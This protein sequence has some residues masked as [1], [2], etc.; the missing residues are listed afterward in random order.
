MDSRHTRPVGPYSCGNRKGS[1]VLQNIDPNARLPSMSEITIRIAPGKTLDAKVEV[2]NGRIIVHSRSGAGANARN[3]DYRPAL[4]AILDRLAANSIKPDIYLDSRPAQKKPLSER[5]IA[6][7]LQLSGS[8]S[9]QFSFLVRA[10][11]A[12]TDSHGAWRRI[13]LHA[14]GQ[15]ELDLTEILNGAKPASVTRGP[16]PKRAV[17]KV[18]RLSATEQ[19]AVTSRHIASA[20]GDLLAGHALPQ[21][22]ASRDYDLVTPD[23]D[24]LAPKKVFGRALELAGTVSNAMPG[25]F[26]A[27]W[28]QPSFEL[29]EA[30]GFSIVPKNE[31]AE[32]AARRKTMTGQARKEAGK[33]ADSIGADREERA[34]IEGDRRM[35]SHLRVERKRSAKAA[36]AKRAAVR[37]ANN[38]KL[39]CERCETDWYQVYHYSVAEAIFDVHHTIPLADMEYGHQTTIEDLLCLCANCHRAEHRKMALGI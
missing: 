19:R 6:K 17:T 13:L 23:G 32:E 1:S 26:S 21:F 18:E 20:V 30:A 14:P 31:A 12:G 7:G 2:Q 15:S 25:H 34:W 36:T 22:A 27:G 5:L 33:L 10:M 38:G 3:P 29:L 8:V 35:A 9:E 11:N 4:E 28:G 37:S 24:R 16:E 39:I